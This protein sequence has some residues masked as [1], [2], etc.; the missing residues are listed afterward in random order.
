MTKISQ[1]TSAS[2][3][4]TSDIVPI[5]DVSDT[6]Q[7]SSGT[8]KKA[9]LAQIAALAS[10][11]ITGWVDVTDHGAVGDGVTD[12][13]D[14]FES[15]ITAVANGGIVYVPPTTDG[16]YK[17]TRT[18]HIGKPFKFVANGSGLGG[19][20][21]TIRFTA[22]FDGPCFKVWQLGSPYGGNGTGFALEGI[23]F[24]AT[25]LTQAATNPLV[26]WE[27]GQVVTRGNRRRVPSLNYAYG[28]CLK[29]GTTLSST[30]TITGATNATPIVITTSAA[31]GLVSD[32]IVCITGVTGNTAANGIWKIT[33][34]SPTTFLIKNPISLQSTVGNGAYVSGGAVSF[35]PVLLYSDDCTREWTTNRATYLYEL[36]QGTTDGLTPDASGSNLITNVFYEVTAGPGL[37]TSI[38]SGPTAPAWSTATIP[39]QTLTVNGITYA[40]RP[41]IIPD[42]VPGA[43]YAVGQMV[44]GATSAAIDA[45]RSNELPYVFLVTSITTGVAG[46][47]YPAWATSTVETWKSSAVG[48]TTEGTYT[49]TTVSGGVTF[50]CIA[51]PNASPWYQDGS[52]V[53]SN[54]VHACVYTHAR[55][56]YSH[57]YTYGASNAGFHV[58]ASA[59]YPTQNAN[60]GYGAFHRS[61][62]C[63]IGM[64]IGGGDANVWTFVQT[65]VETAG[66][67]YRTTGLG[68]PS[69]TTWEAGHGGVGILDTSFLGTNYIGIHVANSAQFPILGVTNDFGG[70]PVVI[71]GEGPSRVTIHHIYS[72]G[73]PP[74]FDGDRLKPRF[75]SSCVVVPGDLGNGFDEDNSLGAMILG[76]SY[77]THG[78]RN[79]VAKLRSSLSGKT[80]YGGIGIPSTYKAVVWSHTDES[81]YSGITHTYDLT[82]TKPQ[83]WWA[84]GN[85]FGTST[86]YILVP[87]GARSGDTQARWPSTVPLGATE[88]PLWVP[89]RI[90]QGPLNLDPRSAEW[91]AAAPSTGHYVAGSLVYNTVGDT[92][93]RGWRCTTGTTYSSALAGTVSAQAQFEEIQDFRPS[94]VLL[95]DPG[96]ATTSSTST[97]SILTITN[98]PTPP[99]GKIYLFRIFVSIQ[100][101]GSTS[102][103][104]IKTLVGFFEKTSAGVLTQNG[105]DVVT[106]DYTSGLNGGSTP[107]FTITSNQPV[108]RITP[109]N[110][111]ST[112]WK[113][114]AQ[115]EQHEITA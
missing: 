61:V 72:E 7:A 87:T 47:S 71:A 39:G 92:V 63:G 58:R 83:G 59:G 114:V 50:T 108:A 66:Y 82:G 105:S 54:R 1:L 6:T 57:I 2:E 38:S 5:V 42:F 111:A 51:L 46:G 115:I 14:A 49:S 80:I 40:A 27:S 67:P 53:F 96:T 34:L 15:A 37:N 44:R 18:I 99:S 93:I 106:S 17:L 23:D 91:A 25:P 13:S 64:F 26:T 77:E 81:S 60:I 90:C 94:D 78:A 29:S 112:D 4:V 97:T 75:L 113:F 55:M 68:G 73:Y 69:A 88:Y 30:L 52:A 103:R 10:G 22:T 8:T 9:T 98:L 101:G 45:S 16:V 20:K 11:G 3:V 12:D 104:C 84:F 33:V 62:Q 107:S 85:A 24:E 76:T 70:G 43:T 41:A 21:S 95:C 48:E 31:H 79:I 74:V 36:F 86:Q 89:Q 56:T 32:K 35:P 100:G 110:A 19:S 102:G 109:A 65:D 28:A